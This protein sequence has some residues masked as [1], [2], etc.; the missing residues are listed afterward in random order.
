MRKRNTEP[1]LRGRPLCIYKNENPFPSLEVSK[2][3]GRFSVCHSLLSLE[4]VTRQ[5]CTGSARGERSENVMNRHIRLS[6]LILT[7]RHNGGEG[8]KKREGD[9]KKG[10]RKDGREKM[11]IRRIIFGQ[12]TLLEFVLDHQNI[13]GE[14]VPSSGQ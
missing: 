12:N 11:R 8:L 7:D 2:G 5:N 13:H 10:W 6:H 1:Q 14:T 9:W 3:D 4:F